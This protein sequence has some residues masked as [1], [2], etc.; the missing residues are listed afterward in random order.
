MTHR[1]SAW[2]VVFNLVAFVCLMLVLLA[3]LGFGAGM[4]EMLIWLVALV[5]GSV[6]I[7]RRYRKA[8]V[9]TRH[10]VGSG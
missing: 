7:V 3:S 4:I 2:S 9:G 1:A 8:K 6:L 5:V 10:A